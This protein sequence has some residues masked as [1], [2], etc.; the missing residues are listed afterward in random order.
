MRKVV[1]EYEG[2]FLKECALR[3]LKVAPESCSNGALANKL[4]ERFRRFFG[5]KLSRH[6][7]FIVA[8]EG[9]PGKCQPGTFSLKLS[10]YK[11]HR[12]KTKKR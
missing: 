2:R 11:K 8:D 10:F 4:T 7:T 9:G 5:D 6:H 3:A 1:S 12:L